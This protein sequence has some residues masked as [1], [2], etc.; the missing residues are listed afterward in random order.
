MSKSITNS[1]Y[2]E[3]QNDLLSIFQN[4]TK[5]NLFDNLVKYYEDTLNVVEFNELWSIYNIDGSIKLRYKFNKPFFAVIVDNLVKSIKPKSY[6]MDYDALK[7]LVE[8]SDYI[9]N[10]K[11][12]LLKQELQK[13]SNYLN[14]ELLYVKTVKGIFQVI[15]IDDKKIK[16]HSIDNTKKLIQYRSY[17]N[18]LIRYDNKEIEEYEISKP[19][20]NYGLQEYWV[21]S[22][23]LSNNTSQL[24]IAISEDQQYYE[25]LERYAL[26]CEI[27]SNEQKERLLQYRITLDDLKFIFDYKMKRILVNVDNLQCLELDNARLHNQYYRNKYNELI[28]KPIFLLDFISLSRFYE[29][30]KRSK[31]IS[32][33]SIEVPNQRIRHK[34]I[35]NIRFEYERVNGILRLR[36]KQDVKTQYNVYVKIPKKKWVIL[37]I[38]NRSNLINLLDTNIKP[39]RFDINH[40]SINTYNLIL[41]PSKYLN[42]NSFKVEDSYSYNTVNLLDAFYNKD[43]YH[44]KLMEYG[45]FNKR[46]DRLSKPPFQTTIQQNPKWEDYEKHL[47]NKLYTKDKKNVFNNQNNRLRVIPINRNIDLLDIEQEQYKTF[48]SFFHSFIQKYNVI[49]MLISFKNL[50]PT[51]INQFIEENDDLTKYLKEIFYSCFFPINIK[52]TI[53]SNYSYVSEKEKEVKEIVSN[54][55]RMMDKP[56]IEKRI[57]SYRSLGIR[58]YLKNQKENNKDLID[59]WSKLM[60]EIEFNPFCS[61]L[62]VVPI[63]SKKYYFSKILLFYNSKINE[64]RNALKLKLINLRDYKGLINNLRFNIYNNKTQL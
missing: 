4:S 59:R 8:K 52:K 36:L 24:Q 11:L 35:H 16:L 27:V 51:E 26:N 31:E 25:D 61:D 6:T 43:K 7:L 19:F 64:Y 15:N 42:I 1:H 30:K 12:S 17:V 9:K 23:G 3:Q 38:N 33:Y 62:F 22:K 40:F 14:R 20:I 49:N 21:K 63:R 46:I 10:T 37:Y 45:R 18:D 54:H 58:D 39:K 44:N 5:N 48:V 32:K 60:R 2:N 56:K 13:V 57:S 34:N 55:Y 50:L 29:D 28:R 53:R 47:I 41:N